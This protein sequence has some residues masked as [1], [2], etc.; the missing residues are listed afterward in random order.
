MKELDF[1]SENKLS[2]LILKEIKVASKQLKGQTQNQINVPISI[3]EIFKDDKF[4]YT[5]VNLGENEYQVG[6]YKKDVLTLC[7]I[8]LRN[9]GV[10]GSMIFNDNG[11]FRHFTIY[12]KPTKEFV[13]LAHYLKKYKD[14]NLNPNE[15]YVRNFNSGEVEYMC[16]DAKTCS[17]LHNKLKATNKS[18]LAWSVC[19]VHR[20]TEVDESNVLK[21]S[22]E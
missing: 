8:V 9:C 4:Q 5:N 15:L 1:I 2:K 19:V 7:E 12:G 17:Y 20:Q 14:F 18:K 16:L 6:F 22:V 11:D 3:E 13:R 10:K 21:I